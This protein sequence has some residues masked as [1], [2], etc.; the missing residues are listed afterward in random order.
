MANE[1]YYDEHPNKPGSSDSGASGGS[2]GGGGGGGS[3]GGA[4][5]YGWGGGRAE[6]ADTVNKT[7]WSDLNAP[8]LK[9]CSNGFLL[10]D[11]ITQELLIG[12]LTCTWAPAIICWIN[13]DKEH[14]HTRCLLISTDAEKA[15]YI[16]ESPNLN[17][18]QRISG[19]CIHGYLT[20]LKPGKISFFAKWQAGHYAHSQMSKVR[21]AVFGIDTGYRVLALKKNIPVFTIQITE[22][23]EIYVNNIRGSLTGNKKFLE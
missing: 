18:Q 9:V 19:M 7:N 1:F 23:Y 14:Q 2:W 6:A 17:E 10:N 15:F 21:F 11:G 8:L 3:G 16:N 12:T 20:W 5:A 13:G 4:P 22:N